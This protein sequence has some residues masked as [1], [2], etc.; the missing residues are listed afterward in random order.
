MLHWV[1]G[2]QMQA[3]SCILSKWPQALLSM[4]LMLKLRICCALI[5]ACFFETKFSCSRTSVHV[6]LQHIRYDASNSQMAYFS[7]TNPQV[8][9]KN[10]WAL[11][12]KIILQDVSEK[13]SLHSRDSVSNSW[14]DM[15]LKTYKMFEN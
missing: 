1:I 14:Y 8:F 10:C 3:N 2:L 4:V 13:T 5:S 6:F 11:G 9:F 7:P 12:W 15:L